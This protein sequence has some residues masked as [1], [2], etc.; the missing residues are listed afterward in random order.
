M[1]TA[2]I[3]TVADGFYVRQAV[4]MM[5]WVDMGGYALAVDAL[6]QPERR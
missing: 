3:V 4:D 6:E 1:M 2:E 5:A